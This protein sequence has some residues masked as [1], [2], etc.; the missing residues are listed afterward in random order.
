MRIAKENNLY[1]IEDTAQAI[2]ST[3]QFSNGSLKKAGTI[4]DMEPLHF[5]FKKFRLH[6]RWG[7]YLPIMQSWQIS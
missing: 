3:Y 1:V 2:G 4:G 6:G 5:S 7:A